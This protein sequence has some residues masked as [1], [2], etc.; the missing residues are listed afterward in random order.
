MGAAEVGA[1]EVSA[2]VPG[3]DGWPGDGWHVTFGDLVEGAALGADV[4]GSIALVVAANAAGR[5]RRPRRGPAAAPPPAGDAV[6]DPS[7]TPGPVQGSLEL[8]GGRIVG[9]TPG[10]VA[11]GAIATLTLPVADARSLLAGNEEPS[12]LFMQ[13]R[14]KVDG[15]MAAVLALLRAT[16][17]GGYGR[18]RS[19]LEGSLAH[20]E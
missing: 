1:D 10:E 8:R 9:W 5:P 19:M 11:A 16:A 6:S 14:L 20:R 18:G 7:S 17:T 2:D 4:T 13:G 12:V 15:D 3:S